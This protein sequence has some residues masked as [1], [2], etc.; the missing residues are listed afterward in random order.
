MLSVVSLF[1][2]PWF[3]QLVRREA[4]ERSSGG[5][6]GD[7]SMARASFAA[8]DSFGNDQ[9]ASQ[10]LA[11][12]CS[13]YDA[14]EDTFRAFTLSGDGPCL[15]AATDG[16]LIQELFKKLSMPHLWEPLR[17]AFDA[18]PTLELDSFR[19]VFL[20][21]LG[22]DLEETFDADDYSAS[23]L[24]DA[25]AAEDAMRTLEAP[26]ESMDELREVVAEHGGTLLGMLHLSPWQRFLWRLKQFPDVAV[27]AG[28]LMDVLD[29]THDG[30]VPV[31]SFDAGDIC[32]HGASLAYHLACSGT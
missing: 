2:A 14:A 23:G 20:Q 29:L 1:L 15:S 24:D 7:A 25:E 22:I 17:V 30:R 28:R 3:E 5:S 19:A 26:N 21:W 6:V 32:A 9:S 12:L 16:P 11:S 13:I 10:M 18:S 27:I 4:P 8:P 31:R